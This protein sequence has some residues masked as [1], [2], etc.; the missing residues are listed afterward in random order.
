MINHLFSKFPALT[1]DLAR[2]TVPCETLAL[3]NANLTS[4][5]LD[6]CGGLDDA[7][8]KVFSTSLSSLQRLELLGPF[9]VR[10]AAWQAFFESHPKLEA[11]L[12][13]Q[14]LHRES[15]EKLS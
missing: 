4:L 14:S 7:S 15:C 12:I 13:T 9:L 2:F 1:L 11:F 5:R 6:F 8:F 3:H 10:T